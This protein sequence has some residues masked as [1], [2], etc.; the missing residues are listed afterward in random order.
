M[1]RTFNLLLLILS[2]ENSRH[3]F[4][5]LKSQLPA[6]EHLRFDTVFLFLSLD[7][8]WCNKCMYY[9]YYYYYYYKS[10]AQVK[11]NQISIQHQILSR[12][13]LILIETNFIVYYFG[14]LCV[15]IHF[16]F[17]CFCCQVVAADEAIAN[18]AAAQAQAIKDECENDLAEAVPALESAISALNTLKPSDIT[19]VKTMKV[20]YICFIE[21][22]ILSICFPFEWF[23]L[24]NISNYFFSFMFDE[25]LPSH[26]LQ[27][28]RISSLL[29]YMNQQIVYI[30][31]SLFVCYSSLSPVIHTFP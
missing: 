9:Y 27:T 19:E 26:L 8:Y 30:T 25:F 28:I 31:S 23:F 29:L 7:W 14:I 13:Q 20:C 4:F 18:E 12:H 3:I 22:L 6:F 10:F 11:M 24:C 5:T 1:R 15:E 21:F 2:N 16:S 17:C